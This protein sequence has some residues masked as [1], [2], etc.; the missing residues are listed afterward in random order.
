MNMGG[1]PPFRTFDPEGPRLLQDLLTRA[2]GRFGGDEALVDRDRRLGF[3]EWEAASRGVALALR[4]RGLKAGDRVLILCESRW[5]TAAAFFG[6]LYA[7]GVACVLH[8]QTP[9][10]KLAFLCEDTE[11]AFLMTEEGLRRTWGEALSPLARR[12]GVFRARPPEGGSSSEP[13]GEEGFPWPEPAGEGEAVETSGTGDEDLAALIYTSGSTGRPK[14]VM[15]SHRAMVFAA[16]SIAHY[17]R[18][19]RGDRILDCLPL[20]FDYGLYQIFFAALTGCAVVFERSFAFPAEVLQTLERESIT[21]FPGVPTIFAMLVSMHR[22]KALRLPGVRIL[23]N[24]AAMLPPEHLDPL[25][26]IFPNARIFKMYGLTECKRTTWL[27]P[28]LLDRKPSSIGKAIPGTEVFLRDEEG[29]PCPPGKPGILHVRGP[30]LMKGYWRRK[31]ETEAM[32]VPGP[33]PGET[34]LRT[35]DW[36]RRDEEGFL[37]FLGRSDDIVKTRGEKVSPLEVENALLSIPG[38]REAAVLGIPDDL[39]GEALRAFVVLEEGEEMSPLE[40]RRACQ[41]LLEPFM[42]PKEVHLLEELPKTENGKVKKSALPRGP[43]PRG[44][45]GGR[46]GHPAGWDD[47]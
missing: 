5:R 18:L 28:D 32:L 31:E 37:Y 40:I 22:R 16:R 41:G 46:G 12:P 17:L 26:E 4:K 2:A 6:V 36:V 39:L 27:D 15:L 10:S 7:G 3:R 29:R 43:M 38:V 23:T 35:G 45:R 44:L 33:E 25:R 8:P 9:P 19:E 11:A 14:G 34:V 42:V 24:T 20:A 13:A 30:H 21:V 1:L 47:R